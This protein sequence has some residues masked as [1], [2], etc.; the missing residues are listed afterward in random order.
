[1]KIEEFAMF[2][3]Y[4]TDLFKYNQ[5]CQPSL[6]HLMVA[7][8]ESLG[9]IYIL[10][11]PRRDIRRRKR[12]VINQDFTSNLVVIQFT[13]MYSEVEFAFKQQVH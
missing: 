8:G 4:R 3:C 9:V 7:F 1:M 12:V 13:Y 11:L 5:T 10:I 6:S 2:D